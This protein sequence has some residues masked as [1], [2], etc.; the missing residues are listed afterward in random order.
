MFTHQLA[1]AEQYCPP[2]HLCFYAMPR[3]GIKTLR[4]IQDHPARFCA[5][6][7]RLAQGM[8]GILL[9]DSP[10]TEQVTTVHCPLT[11]DYYVRDRRLPL[12]QRPGLVEHDSLQLA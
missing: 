8:L 1:I 12:R 2:L 11:T 5:A 3:D 9:S 10:I 4:I 6:H 7:D